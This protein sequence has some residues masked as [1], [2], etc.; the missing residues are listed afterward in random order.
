MLGLARERLGDRWGIVAVALA[1][2]LMHL[3][4]RRLFPTAALGVLF[5]TLT[6]RTG[7]IWP[8]IVAHFLN[9]AIAVA[10]LVTVDGEVSVPGEMLLVA[11]GGV[12][13]TWWL[14]GRDG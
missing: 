9:N 8:A 4:L 6:V 5:G 12:L 2:G 13:V 3:D 7:S 11:A 10:V 1:F 14:V